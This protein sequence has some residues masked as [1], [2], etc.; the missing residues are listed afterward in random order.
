MAWLNIERIPDLNLT[1]TWV[2]AN[3]VSTITF[4]DKKDEEGAYTYT[5]TWNMTEEWASRLSSYLVKEHKQDV[6]KVIEVKGGVVTKADGTIQSH[7][8]A[9]SILLMHAAGEFTGEMNGNM[10]AIKFRGF[11]L[12]KYLK[13]PQ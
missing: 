1:G 2:G 12:M 8:F 10:L 3:E 6:G 4:E 9:G 5:L 13:M 7:P 11:A